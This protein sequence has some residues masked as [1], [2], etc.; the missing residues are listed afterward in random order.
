MEL[1]KTRRGVGCKGVFWP[2]HVWDWGDCITTFLL[3]LMVMTY[4]QKAGFEP[5][6]FRR[7]NRETLSNFPV[8]SIIYFLTFLALFS[9]LSFGTNGATS[10]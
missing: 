9:I 2:A 1:N 5:Q 6:I 3:S 8:K 7:V 10:A 4:P